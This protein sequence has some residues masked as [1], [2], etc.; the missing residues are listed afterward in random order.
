ML[1][2]P[3]R[4]LVLASAV[5]IA[6]V[7][8]T[9]ITQ[10]AW[11]DNE[12]AHGGVGA[13]SPGDCASNTMFTN[14]ASGRQLTGTVAGTDLETLVGVRGVRAVNDGTATMPIPNDLS[15]S[16]VDA[17]TYVAKLPVGILNSTILAPALGLGLPVG[18]LGT[19]T[20][21]SQAEPNGKAH[22]AAGLVSDQTGAVDVTGT[23]QG[24]GTG[25]TAAKVN[26]E[27]LV[28]AAL[29]GLSL[30][31][32]AVA[33]SSQV[34]GCEMASGWPRPAA[35]PKV[36]R[37]YG[38]AGIDLNA[39]VPAVGAL[40]QVYTGLPESLEALGAESGVVST[41][42][43]SGLFTLLNPVV[44]SLS[45]LLAP[46]SL[47]NFTTKV[48]LEK[49]DLTEVEKLLTAPLADSKGVL[50]VD[51]SMGT[52]R[53]NI[54]SL[55]GGEHGLNNL[56][57]NHEV[58]LD[59]AILNRIATELTS[60]L[61]VW[62]GKV[63]DAVLLAVRSVK[64]HFTS[65]SN[66]R[67]L[68][69]IA[70]VEVDAGPAT[71]GQF[72]DGTAPVPIVSVKLLGKLEAPLVDGLT[73]ALLGGTLGVVTN[74]LSATVFGANALVPKL[75]ASLAG[76]LKPAVTAVGKILKPFSSLVSIRVNVQPDRPWAGDKPLDVSAQ[77]GEYKVSAIRVGLVNS[78]SLLSLSLA[79]SSSGPAKLRP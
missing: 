68:L 2:R 16:K 43:S 61:D 41:G 20:Q 66:V 24:A 11:I 17:N 26:L 32:G 44:K 57:A 36:A 78:A 12:W 64:F 30:D 59:D 4:L 46:L 67:L 39:K 40:S 31:V 29:A 71:L 70:S 15:V 38:I 65:T 72:L 48:T 42:I 50:S 33:S 56:N 49:L 47:G 60:L 34:D 79:N 35:G 74:V 62:K 8:S 5:V 3:R 6:V 21:W 73:S 10:A 55:V 75:G 52:V 51:L 9:S 25:P 77:E 37:D 13:S 58:V 28:P 7:V 45:T 18:A 22:G 14:Q 63:L 69:P 23:A 19:Y 53:I 54:A 1:T 76:L 27:N